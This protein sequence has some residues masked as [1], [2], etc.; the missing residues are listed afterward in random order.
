MAITAA[1][2]LSEFSGFLTREQSQPI[3]E[4]AARSSTVQSLAPE[5]SLG[6]NGKSIPVVML[7][8]AFGE[9]VFLLR[10]KHRELADFGKIVREAGLPIEDRQ[11]S[12]TGH[13]APSSG[14]GPR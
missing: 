5:V 10:F 8:P 7:A 13:I 12:C 11:S 14:S 9:H 3:F 4:R 2:T 6:G 1:T